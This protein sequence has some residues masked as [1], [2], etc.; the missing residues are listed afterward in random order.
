MRARDEAAQGQT[1]RQSDITYVRANERKRERACE[2]A[3]SGGILIYILAAAGQRDERTGE[4]RKNS[5][6][7]NG[8]KKT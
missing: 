5:G 6:R 8:E 3:S 1:D 7:K 4:Y 2:R